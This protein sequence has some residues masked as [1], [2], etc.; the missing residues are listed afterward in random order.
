LFIDIV[1]KY[2][3]TFFITGP[4]F[5]AQLLNYEGIKPLES[6]K[7]FVCAGAS[8]SRRI[9]ENGTKLFPNG[10]VRELYGSTEAG[11]NTLCYPI[12]KYGATGKVLKR[13]ELQ[14][15]DENGAKLGPMERGEICVRFRSACLVMSNHFSNY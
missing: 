10:Q 9:A 4:Y 3:V 12:N 11:L 13:Y 5:L 15:I 1:E 2:K 14:I 7:N 6:M 8:M